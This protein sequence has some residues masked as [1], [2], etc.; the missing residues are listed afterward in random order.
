M[1]MPGAMVFV[2]GEDLLGGLGSDVMETDSGGKG[3]PDLR[4]KNGGLKI[5]QVGRE[6]KGGEG[7]EEVW[8]E[9]VSRAGEKLVPH[10]GR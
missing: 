1:G 4:G 8:G 3:E 2:E 5:T 10:V 9:P 6:P 7:K